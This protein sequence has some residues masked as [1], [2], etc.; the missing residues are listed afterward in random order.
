MLRG[1]WAKEQAM[2]DQAASQG[3]IRVQQLV[4]LGVPERTAYRRCANGGPWRRLLP[5]VV[6]LSNG[7]PSDRQ[8]IAAGLVYA[9]PRAVLTGLVACR[10][11][12][13]RR[14]PA[15]PTMHVHLLV[16]NVRQVR[17]GKFVTVERTER[18]PAPVI[19][20]GIPLAPVPRACIDAARRLEDPRE[21][22][23]LLADAVQRGLCS[24]SALQAE[25][26][27]CSRRGTAM[28]RAVL[29]EVSD[30]ARSAAERDAQHVWRETGLPEPWW[31]ASVRD[32][33]GR[34]LGI[35]DAWWDDVA[36]AWEIN[37]IEYHLSPADYARTAERAARFAAAGV[38]VVP[39]LPR[40]LRRDRA[41]VVAELRS[42][43]EQ[44]ANRPR[45][46]LTATPIAAP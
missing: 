10:L 32:R 13:V 8:R 5:G 27:R 33:D 42:A 41:A 25:L 7:E 24:V 19:R 26:A 30:G 45:P 9:G 4:E 29:A 43:Y 44:A 34:L 37:S 14:G 12:G 40:R 11:H 35:A 17:V 6:M 28:P 18:L 2:L 38:L 21:V 16:P 3:V 46:A 1:Q 31:N 36:L 23:E 20:D 39:T 15:M 22:T